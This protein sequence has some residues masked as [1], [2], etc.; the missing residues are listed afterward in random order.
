MKLHWLCIFLYV[1][2][3]ATRLVQPFCLKYKLLPYECTYDSVLILHVS[4]DCTTP[5]LIVKEFKE[6]AQKEV[7]E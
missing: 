7:I 2:I 6:S 1:T 4:A 3:I 5:L